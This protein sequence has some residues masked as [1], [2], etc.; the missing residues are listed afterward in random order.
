MKRFRCKNGP[1]TGHTLFLGLDGKTAVF[2]V[3]GETGYY[4]HGYW[5]KHA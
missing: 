2:T 3:K 5:M 1:W 4:D